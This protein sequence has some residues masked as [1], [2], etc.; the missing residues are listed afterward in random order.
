MNVIVSCSL[1]VVFNQLVLLD[2]QSIHFDIQFS[3][4]QD[5]VMEQIYTFEDLEPNF[6]LTD[7]ANL[8]NRLVISAK[9]NT[10]TPIMT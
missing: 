8:I 6:L 10:L 5:R 7:L 9:K 3:T 1:Y 4:V 2:K